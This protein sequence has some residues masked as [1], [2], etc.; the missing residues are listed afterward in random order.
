MVYMVLVTLQDFLTL[1]CLR[2]LL[3]GSVDTIPQIADHMYRQKQLYKA[4]HNHT[5]V[6]K[7]EEFKPG[8]TATIQKAVNDDRDAGDEGEAIIHLSPFSQRH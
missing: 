8:S 2:F 3:N 5:K 1:R 7:S 4:R 6:V